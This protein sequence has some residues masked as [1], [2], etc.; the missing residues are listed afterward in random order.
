MRLGNSIFLSF[1]ALILGLFLW[2][3]PVLAEPGFVVDND[4][5]RWEGDIRTDSGGLITVMADNDKDKTNRFNPGRYRY[6]MIR[7]PPEVAGLEA[8]LAAKRLGDIREK[9]G[10]LYRKYRYLGWADL[11]CYCEGMALLQGGDPKEAEDAFAR[12]VKALGDQG[13]NHDRCR[14]GQVLAWQ[15]Q[16]KRDEAHQELMDLVRSPTP[17]VA[18]TAL[19]LR[20]QDFEKQGD[21]RAAAADYLKI[22]LCFKDPA[23][24]KNDD[25]TAAKQAAIRLLQELKESKRAKTLEAL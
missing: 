1:P 6:A 16:K 7:K 11:I 18:M 2:T 24:K 19:T 4:G 12:G 21:K 22:V 13:E 5:K 3:V 15:K 17:S 10:S 23:D 20:A 25:R 14:L 9:A 8:A